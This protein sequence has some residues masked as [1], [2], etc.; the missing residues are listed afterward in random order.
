M[1]ADEIHDPS[2]EPVLDEAESA[3]VE[4]QPMNVTR[5]RKV[6]NA[7]RAKYGRVFIP[8]RF[9]NIWFA[10]WTAWTLGLDVGGATATNVAAKAFL[11]KV[12]TDMEADP[13]YGHDKKGFYRPFDETRT[14]WTYLDLH[15]EERRFLTVLA[16]RALNKQGKH[17][18][19]SRVCRRLQLLRRWSHDE[20]DNEQVF[21]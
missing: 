4:T 16:K 5:A 12:A 14:K 11:C 8:R 1:S 20:Q 7:W 15:R 13:Q 9:N 6:I 21:A 18:E 17:R 3:A 19:P 10:S 2:L